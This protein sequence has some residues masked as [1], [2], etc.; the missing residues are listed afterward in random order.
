V[1]QSKKQNTKKKHLCLSSEANSETHDFDVRSSSA[2]AVLAHNRRHS[3]QHLTPSPSISR[4]VTPPAQHASTCAR[5]THILQCTHIMRAQQMSPLGHWHFPTDRTSS[6]TVCNTP[7]VSF[8]RPRIPCSV[9]THQSIC[10]PPLPQAARY[11]MNHL[12][13]QCQPTEHR[14]PQERSSRPLSHI[15]SIMLCVCILQQ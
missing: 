14:C 15:R 2:K 10:A 9:S 13:C 3:H 8:T 6:S 5:T 12:A 4:Y 7:S 1:L 11:P